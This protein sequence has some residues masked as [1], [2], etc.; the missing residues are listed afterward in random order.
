MANDTRKITIEI[1]GDGG[2]KESINEEKK[3]PKTQTKKI[4]KEIIKA[5]AFKESI[6]TVANLAVNVAEVSVNRYFTLTEDY[7]A[8]N[9]YNNVKNSIAKG[10]S[11]FKVVGSVGVQVAT[12]NYIGAAAT[13]ISYGVNELMEYRQRMGGYYQALNAT[14]YQTG[15]SATR[16]GLVDGGRGTEN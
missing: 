12:G 4:K 9:I 6:K 1:L 2:N 5:E 15:F 8:Q 3:S 14:N 10:K 7:L 16:A 13:A 11:L